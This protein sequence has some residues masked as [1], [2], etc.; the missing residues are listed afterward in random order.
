M[1]FS[2]SAYEAKLLEKYSDIFPHG[3]IQ[4]VKSGVTWLANHNGISYHTSVMVATDGVVYEQ[5]KSSILRLGLINLEKPFTGLTYYEVRSIQELKDSVNGNTIFKVKLNYVSPIGIEITLIPINYFDPFSNGIDNYYTI[6][7]VNELVQKEGSAQFEHAENIR[8][9]LEEKLAENTAL[10][11]EMKIKVDNILTVIHD[12]IDAEVP[13]VSLIEKL[14]SINTIAVNNSEN[15]R[16]LEDRIT[17][18]EEG[19]LSGD[20]SVDVSN[21]V[22]KPELAVFK[23]EVSSHIDE[24]KVEL[25]SYTDNAVANKPQTETIPATPLVPSK[26]TEEKVEEG[27]GSSDSS[28]VTPPAKGEEE[29][30]KEPVEVPE[31]DSGDSEGSKEESQD[32]VVSPGQDSSS[33]PQPDSQGDGTVSGDSSETVTES[34]ASSTTSPD[35]TTSSTEGSV[36]TQ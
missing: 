27:N 28:T 7:Q 32:Q 16:N 9:K 36:V 2:K 14:A 26:P 11:E 25:K 24:V 6:Q 31:V 35:G 4:C 8:V 13:G 30:P 22:S 33:Q 20:V 17:A 29:L 12:Q 3:F 1:D 23:S 19:E 21:L 10:L 5:N 15:L 34:D 18:I